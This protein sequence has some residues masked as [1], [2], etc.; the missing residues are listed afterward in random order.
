MERA[1]QAAT[2]YAASS[3]RLAGKFP[4][5]DQEELWIVDIKARVPGGACRVFSVVV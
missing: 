5:N 1:H 2:A 3:P 4:D